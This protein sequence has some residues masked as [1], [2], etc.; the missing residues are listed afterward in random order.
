MSTPNEA[1]DARHRQRKDEIIAAGR[2]CFRQ[3][4]F[5]AASMAQLAAEASL[6]VG[7]IYR[8]FTNKD[9]IIEEMVKRIIDSRL[10]YMEETATAR[11]LPRLL[12]WRQALD[13]DDEALMLEVG[14]EASRN[15]VVARMLAEADS[16]MFTH[17][18]QNVKKTYPHFSDEHIRTC[19]EVFAVLV[20]GTAFRRLTP[21]KASAER[22]FILYQQLTDLLFKTEEK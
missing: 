5:H 8:Y 7:Q 18:C 1:R 9:A 21:Q 4:G 19:V 22:L 12:A 17:A 16:R 6:S 3:S 11:N 14:A 10:V 13:E 2:R 15:P 20:E